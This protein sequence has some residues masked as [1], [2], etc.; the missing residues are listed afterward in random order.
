V[1]FTISG[2]DGNVAYAL[3]VDDMQVLEGTS[4]GAVSGTFTVPDLVDC[5]ST[6]AVDAE[7]HTPGRWR[8]VESDLD[9]LGSALPVA[10]P[11]TPSVSAPVP[12]APQAAPS[13]EA[14]HSPGAAEG[15][16]G[17]PAPTPQAHRRR[18]QSRKRQVVEP[19][20]H[21][22]RGRERRGRV[23]RGRHR[24]KHRAAARHRRSKGASL[25][26]GPLSG[27]IPDPG[28]GPHAATEPTVPPPAVLVATGARGTD[29]GA[30]P[31]V[32]VPTLLGLAAL[33]LASTALLRRRRLASR[34][35]S[36]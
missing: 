8:K 30:Y 21:V 15:P 23:H 26:T 36:D 19:P 13:P 22:T 5:A 29:G 3:E 14:I 25:E 9:Y 17:A 6:V 4:D 12:V 24:R 1:H 7:I 20:R 32:V 10:G 2:V 34:R 28:N 27:G 35:D 16:P 31:A 33:A 11:P 18:R